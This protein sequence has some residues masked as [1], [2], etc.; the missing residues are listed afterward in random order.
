MK[1]IQEEVT[2][3][4]DLYQE[5]MTVRVQPKIQVSQER[6]LS[7]MDGC[8]RRERLNKMN[9]VDAEAIA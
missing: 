1:A 2:A 7:S 3:K 5:E 8:L 6:M 4:L 9:I